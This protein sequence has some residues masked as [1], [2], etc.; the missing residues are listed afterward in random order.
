MEIHT[1]T[2]LTWLVKPSIGRG[3]FIISLEHGQLFSVR[4]IVSFNADHNLVI[5]LIPQWKFEA[6]LVAKLCPAESLTCTMWNDPGCFSSVVIVPTRPIL[7]PPV[8]IHKLPVI[9]HHTTSS[10]LLGQATT[11]YYFVIIT[12]IVSMNQVLFALCQH[13]L[14]TWIPHTYGELCCDSW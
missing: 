5:L 11:A 12:M 7:C 1:E 13:L 4:E 6:Y 8:I 3:H 9:E 2:D 10:I 14:Y